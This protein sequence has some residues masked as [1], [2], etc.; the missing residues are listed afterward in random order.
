[1]NGVFYPLLHTYLSPFRGIRVPARFGALV[2]LTLAIL[3]GF[4]MLAVLRRCQARWRGRAVVAA[5]AIAV[6][7]DA[8]PVLSLEP[9]WKEPPSIYEQLSGRFGVVLAELPMPVNAAEL[10]ELRG[11]E[12]GMKVL[13]NTPE[14]AEVR[15]IIDARAAELRNQLEVLEGY[16][17]VRG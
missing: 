12:A 13:S 1:L 14:G 6:L 8:W 16:L 7:I 11:M 17:G 15:E 9:V 10:Q 2:G 3:A 5:V 4:G